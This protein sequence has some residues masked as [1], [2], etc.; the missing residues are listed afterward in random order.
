MISLV[1][2]DKYMSCGPARSGRVAIPARHVRGRRPADR[3]TAPRPRAT[4][5]V[6]RGARAAAGVRF[7]V[8]R[9]SSRHGGWRAIT[10]IDYT[11]HDGATYLKMT[12]KDYFVTLYMGI[13]RYGRRNKRKYIRY[14]E[15]PAAKRP[16]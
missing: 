1:V 8:A 12:S 11:A 14:C 4:R 5:G 15:C 7:T 6:D 16:C 13:V 3:A 2:W 10:E 9:P